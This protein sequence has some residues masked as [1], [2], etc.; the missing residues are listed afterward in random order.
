MHG[1]WGGMTEEERYT[2]VKAHQQLAARSAT[3]DPVDA[4]SR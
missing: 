2:A 1:I 4:H 3:P